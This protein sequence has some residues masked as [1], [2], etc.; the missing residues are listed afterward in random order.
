MAEITLDYELLVALDH[1]RG[2][3]S[4]AGLCVPE[5]RS[6]NVVRL[7][8]SL[9]RA[10]FVLGYSSSPVYGIVHP[11]RLAIS[12]VLCGRFSPVVEIFGEV[13]LTVN[14]ALPWHVLLAGGF[15]GRSVAV[16]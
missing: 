3:H 16:W 10:T 2:R 12:I 7:G 13:C 6:H 14:R 11:K 5:C 4:F 1:G 8:C 9:W 15:D